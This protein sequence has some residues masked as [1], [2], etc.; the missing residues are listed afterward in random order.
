MV[1]DIQ[2]T[3]NAVEVIL[4]STFVDQRHLFEPSLF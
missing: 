3:N 2:E 1:C 4:T